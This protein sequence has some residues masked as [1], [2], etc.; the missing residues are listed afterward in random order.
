MKYVG[1]EEKKESLVCRKIIY[2]ESK[3]ISD[4]IYDKLLLKNELT[5]SE[6]FIVFGRENQLVS[7]MF[8]EKNR[9]KKNLAQTNSVFQGNLTEKRIKNYNN[10]ED[11]PKKVKYIYSRN[12]LGFVEDDLGMLKELNGKLVY[13]GQI[14][15]SLPAFPFLYSVQ[16]KKIGLYR[17]YTKKEIKT[18]L[19]KAGFVIEY[20]SF[21]DLFGASVT[22]LSQ[23]L[24]PN[25]TFAF[26]NLFFFGTRIFS[27]IS[28]LIGIFGFNKIFGNK[29]FVIARKKNRSKLLEPKEFGDL[30]HYYKNFFERICYGNFITNKSM[31]V[32]HKKIEL[33]NNK[34][35]YEKVL[36]VGA[37]SGQHLKYVK[38]GFKEYLVTDLVKPK[39]SKILKKD[40]RI[41]TLVVNVEKIPFSDNYFDRVI[42]TCLLHHVDRPGLAIKEIDRVLRKDGSATIFLP[43]DPGIV[44]R[45]I[46]CLTSARYAR[47]MGFQG[48]DLL[49]AKDHRNH[50]GSLLKLI[51]Y[52]F[53]G[54]NMKIKYFPF[55]LPSWN[56]NTYI[57]IE[58]N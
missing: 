29:I 22:F 47:K 5:I 4:K 46:R 39:T 24:S 12:T 16:D 20:F 41:K 32:V 54:R 9:R 18:K 25:K 11:I 34:M 21:H 19:N 56:L 48:Y 23:F 8:F 36:E 10:I 37:G 55:L 13:G 38:H 2:R 3:I 35:Y 40:G 52:G 30:S 58:V 27:S 7:D 26:K 43:C 17:R 31:E 33:S 1:V 6:K 50:V 42:V 51:E 15:L 44:L 49:N 14:V 57:V 45:F 53:P 28:K